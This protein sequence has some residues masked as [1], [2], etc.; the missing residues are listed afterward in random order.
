MRLAGLH[1]TGTPAKVSVKVSTT[2]KI[3][4]LFSRSKASIVS[5]TI[6][7]AGSDDAAASAPAAAAPSPPPPRG[8]Q[9]AALAIKNETEL[10]I[11]FLLR[12]HLHP[13]VLICPVKRSGEMRL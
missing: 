11:P 5:T 8:Q 9:L 7:A 3:M 10:V 1:S 6:A 2:G 4:R 12:S 13:E